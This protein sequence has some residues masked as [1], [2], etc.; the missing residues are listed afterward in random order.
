LAVGPGSTITP[1][2]IDRDA[3]ADL[4]GDAQVCVMNSMVSARRCFKSSSRLSAQRAQ[5][6]ER[7]AAHFAA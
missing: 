5:R 1:F 7:M 3:V 4:R 2:C 6:K